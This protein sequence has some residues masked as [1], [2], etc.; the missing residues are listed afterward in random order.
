M[1][2]PIAIEA[3]RRNKDDVFAAFA[4]VNNMEHY[5]SFANRHEYTSAYFD[6]Q[7][8]LMVRAMEKEGYEQTEFFSGNVVVCRI[9]KKV[10][11]N[12]GADAACQ[13]KACESKMSVTKF[14]A[15]DALAREKNELKEKVAYLTRELASKNRTAS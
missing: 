10:R 9:W 2:S 15:V 4:E 14:L 1:D 6:L 5:V 11:A 3:L 8:L 7:E 12:K 13:P